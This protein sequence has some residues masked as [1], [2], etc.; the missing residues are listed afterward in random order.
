M[1]GW[2]A[3]PT[4]WQM[5]PGGRYESECPVCE[6][7]LV[8]YHRNAP[9]NCLADAAMENDFPCPMCYAKLFVNRVQVPGMPAGKII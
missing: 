4:N 7:R 5:T 1:I 6:T 2:S 8:K 3:A 9:D